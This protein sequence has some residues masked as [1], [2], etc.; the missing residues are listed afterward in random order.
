MVFCL[1]TSGSMS[2]LPVEKS[3]EVVKLCLQEMGPHD[4]FQV[5]RF[6][7]D[8]ATF[9]EEPVPATRANIQRA[10]EF[11]D[12]MQGRGGTEMLQG[13]EACLAFPEDPGRVR[14]VAFLTD[15][16]IGNESEILARI[17]E[18]LGSA[19]I[20][21]FG[22]GSSVNRYLLKKMAQLGRGA[23]RFVRYDE[24]PDE[25]VRTFVDRIS[26][27]YLT[28]IEIDWGGLDAFEVYP[29]Y[30]PDLFA[31]Q[32]VVL[33]GRYEEPG[34]AA[35][36]ISGHIAGEPWKTR[37]AARFPAQ[38]HENEAIAVLWA[39]ACIDDLMDQMHEGEDE[40]V[41]AAI[42][43]L[44]LD[45]R[46]MSPYTS[47]VAVE[48]KV[49]NRDG[50]QVTVQVPVPMPEGVSYEGVFGPPGAALRRVSALGYAGDGVS[51]GGGGARAGGGYVGGAGGFGGGG[52]GGMRGGGRGAAARRAVP[53]QAPPVPVR[54]WYFSEADAI[55]AM[56]ARS[57]A[58]WIAIAATDPETSSA[59]EL[60]KLVRAAGRHIGLPGGAPA[61]LLP[62]HLAQIGEATN[63]RLV[64]LTGAEAPELSG[65]ARAALAKFVRNGGFLLVD[66]RGNAFYRGIVKLLQES[67]P[68]AT[69]AR[70]S[71]RHDVFRG[72]SM[73]FRLA[74]GCPVVRP[75]GATGP[76]QGLFIGD[77]LAVFI[78]R[79]ALSEAWSQPEGEGNR[80]AYHMGVNLIA[81]AL[82]NA[83]AENLPR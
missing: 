77:R 7:G 47:F 66:S 12:T 35:I 48:E 6:A 5:V 59:G 65:E 30:W 26:R 73:P 20:F 54:M 50:R 43:D 46:L 42:I 61:T 70:V 14:I 22:I 57:D 82:Q 34:E 38:E 72:G 9:A 40:E 64:I 41:K 60:G 19:R 63:L 78:S 62:K 51:M 21:S 76:A 52:G 10:T 80:E 81:Y 79:G 18:K 58:L 24:H 15:G 17:Q 39:R 27:P 16:Y 71:P 31:D 83:P 23:A 29:P 56:G 67:L 49:V 3:K 25:A 4:T 1:D 53:M 11:V 68:E 8:S 2:G 74:G 44:A 28:D 36:T 33:H 55:A 37:V 45:Y 13:I 75:F 32:P 69:F